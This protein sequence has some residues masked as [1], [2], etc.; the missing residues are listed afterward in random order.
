MLTIATATIKPIV[1]WVVLVP[2]NATSIYDYYMYNT[3]VR[4]DNLPICMDSAP[5]EIDNQFLEKTEIYKSFLKPTSFVCA[6]N[7]WNP[8]REIEPQFDSGSS[9]KTHVL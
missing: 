1:L 7:D 4:Y 2:T 8:D 5:N 3:Q 9:K 6:P